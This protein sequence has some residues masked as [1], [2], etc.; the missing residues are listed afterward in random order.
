M[1]S[2]MNRT[3]LVYGYVNYAYCPRDN[4]EKD[5]E[6]HTFH[7]IFDALVKAAAL[8]AESGGKLC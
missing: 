6:S 8:N 1:E 4:T 3:M 5:E 7:P 2:R